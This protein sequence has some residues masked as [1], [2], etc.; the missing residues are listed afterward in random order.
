MQYFVRMLQQQGFVLAASRILTHARW[1]QLRALSIFFTL[2]MLLSCAEPVFGATHATPIEGYRVVH[3]YP[4]D[5]S[6]FTQGLV[7]VDGMLYEGTGLNGRSSMRMVDLKTGRVLQE[8]NLPAKYFGEG[9]T[10]WGNN[11]I[12]LTWTSHTGFVYDRFSFR[13]LKTF[14]YPGEGWGL[15]HDSRHLIMSDG[16]AVLRLLDP[17][18]F[19]EVGHISVTDYGQPVLNL[20]ELE[21]IHQEVFANIWQT[22]RIARISP[23]T[24]KVLAW[25]NLAGL[26]PADQRQNSNAVLNGIAYDSQ[27]ERLFV[28]GKLWPKMF[29]IKLVSERVRS[30]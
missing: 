6:A 9:L 27:H 30:K 21:Y 28:T 24:G 14:S 1:M 25:I 16:T 11:L 17:R 3:T 22:D 5:S 18:T 8:H 10:D 2:G 13:L 4:H 29:E 20:N 19:R 12:E 26:L 23:V 15:T 7:Y